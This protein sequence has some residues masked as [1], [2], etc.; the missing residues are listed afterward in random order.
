MRLNALVKRE[1]CAKVAEAI[2]LAPHLIMAKAESSSGGR[3]KGAI[4][5]GAIEALIAAIYF[6]GGWESARHFVLAL[7]NDAFMTLQPELRDAKT[8]LQE[9]AQS[10]VLGMRLQPSYAVKNRSGPDHAPVFM[11]EVSVPGQELSVGDGATKRDAEQDA[12]RRMLHRL[13][14]WKDE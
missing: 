5:S 13:G 14:V 3:Q 6:D 8:A 2:N 1:A 4:L 11:V 12:A 7:W 9:W 10:G